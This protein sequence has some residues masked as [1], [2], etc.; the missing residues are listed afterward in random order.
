MIDIKIEALGIDKARRLMTVAPKRLR[1]AITHWM[2]AEKKRYVGTK[3]YPLGKFGRK[4]AGLRKGAGAPSEFRRPGKWGSNVAG[5]FRG[6]F[7]TAKEG[8]SSMM[9]KWGPGLKKKTP[10]IQGLHRLDQ[11]TSGKVVESASGM[12][13]PVYR[14]LIKRNIPI[15]QKAGKNIA[16]EHMFKNMN[17]TVIRKGENTY[18]VDSDDRDKRGKLRKSALLFV[19]KREVSLTPKFDFEGGF[20]ADESNAIKR[21]ENEVKRTIRALEM[22]YLSFK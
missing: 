14:N 10:F 2:M 19:K 17:Y 22:G 5:A 7:I 11:S 12:A 13:I 9:T 21:S 3:R 6:F 8:G 16:L 1:S 4:V 18:Y 20:K 15:G